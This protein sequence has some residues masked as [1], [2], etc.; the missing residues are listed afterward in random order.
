MKHVI[1]MISALIILSMTMHAENTGEKEVIYEE[2]IAKY[3]ND[4][5]EES[6]KLFDKLITAG[7]SS[8]ELYY[9]AG[10]AAFKMGD[11]PT[12]ILNY[13][14]ALLF[15]PF[16]DD[17][18][19]NLQIARTYTIDK[20]EAIPEIFIVRWFR[21]FSLLLNTNDWALISLLS[22]TVSLVL[23]AVFLFSARYKTK[24]YTFTGAVIIFIVSIL[25]FVLSLTNKSLTI[26]NKEAIVFEPQVTGRSSPGTGGRE[27]FV[28]HEGAKVK[29]EDQLGEWYE[30]RLS[31]GTVGW[32][33][34]NF[35]KKITH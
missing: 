34:M 22:F 35:I 7:Y 15:K 33:P 12:A 24:R 1:C 14:K 30:I 13:E 21:K 19:H 31:D 5:F 8:F 10:N 9:N 26:N 16:N 3:R 23:L 17:V 6:L 11:I 27:L 25:T 2:A 18:L 32:I 28:I 29:V 4:N 20:L